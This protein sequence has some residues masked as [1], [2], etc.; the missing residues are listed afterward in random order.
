MIS[1]DEIARKAKRNY[2]RFL[3]TT[4]TGESFFPF[5]LPVG[6]L[7]KD[8]IVLKKAVADLID[9]SKETIGYGY[10]LVLRQRKTRSYGEQSLPKEIFVETELDFL[11]LIKKEKEVSTF[12]SNAAL[13]Q[14]SGLLLRTWIC[15]NPLKIVD[16][17]GDWENLLKVCHYFVANLQPNLYI[18]ELP[19]A[20][21]TKFIEQNKAL[22]RSLLEVLLP[23]E[24]LISVETGEKYAF[25]KRFSLKY[26]ESLIRLR[27]LDGVIMEKYCLQTSDMSITISEFRRLEFGMPRCFITENMLTFLTLPPLENS[28]AIFGCGFASARLRDTEWLLRCP[29]FYWGDMDEHGFGILSQVRSHFPQTQSVMMDEQT[30]ARFSPFA[31]DVAT[32]KAE[33]LSHLTNPEHSLYEY[34]V[35]QHKRLEQE[36]ISQSYVNEYLQSLE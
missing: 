1:S 30:Y 36:R 26:P 14:D 23:T 17:A 5:N 13:I 19:I 28:I 10:Q 34:L 31:V 27:I 3:I 18:R 15:D 35:N 9:N 11:K 22:L 32:Q 29:I 12:K 20:V 24:N 25:E 33:D 7:P 2:K 6:A 21:H 16:N 4:V 8:F